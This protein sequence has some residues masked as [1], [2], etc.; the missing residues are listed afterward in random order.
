MAKPDPKTEQTIKTLTVARNQAERACAQA[1]DGA[2]AA[3]K[4]DTHVSTWAKAQRDAA[5]ALAHDVEAVA[6]NIVA[7]IN[8]IKA[9]AST[10]TLALDTQPAALPADTT[11]SEIH[12]R[13]RLELD[14]AHSAIDALHAD[15]ERLQHR[16]AVLA[17]VEADGLPSPSLRAAVQRLSDAKTAIPAKLPYSADLNTVHEAIYHL[18]MLTVQWVGARK[19]ALDLARATAAMEPSRDVFPVDLSRPLCLAFHGQAL[20]RDDAGAVTRCRITAIVV[21]SAVNDPNALPIVQHDDGFLWSGVLA[22]GAGTPAIDVAGIDLDHLERNVLVYADRFGVGRAVGE[23]MRARVFPAGTPLP[24]GRVLDVAALWVAIR[25]L[26]SD[27]ARRVAAAIEMHNATQ[28]A[29]NHA[30]TAGI[31]AGARD[32]AGDVAGANHG[33]VADLP[34]STGPAELSET[35]GGADQAP[36]REPAQTPVA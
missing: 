23:P 25:R 13:M 17:R 19:D 33:N 11:I 35:P 1:V 21:T 4:H 3:Y 10:L 26:D 30:S 29:I 16:S 24:D 22:S 18:G 14:A 27:L 31:D 5:Q 34:A 15:R 12:H 32:D 8:A 6:A 36:A 2:V 28:E 20:A 7:E 9:R